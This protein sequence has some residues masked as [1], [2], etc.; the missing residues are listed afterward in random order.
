MIYK[1]CPRCKTK[2]AYG[3]S[4]PNG[5]YKLSRLESAKVYNTYQRKNMAFYNSSN[6]AK[7]SSLCKSKCKGIDIYQLYKYGNYIYGTTSHHIVPI[8]D[9]MNKSLDINNLI[10][11]NHASHAEIH[12]AYNKSPEDKT[13]MQMYLFEVIK[14]YESEYR[15]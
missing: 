14:K 2:I 6:W 15:G 9:D 10:Y 11:V 3:E 7:L 4:C 8:D 1:L 5:C 12:A 13:K